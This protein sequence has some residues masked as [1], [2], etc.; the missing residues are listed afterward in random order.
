MPAL[1][2]PVDHEGNTAATA[3][4]LGSL[5]LRNTASGSIDMAGDQDFFR[6]TAQH[7]GKVTINIS[8]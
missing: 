5:D 2:G 8:R 7:T 3:V 4:N 1:S 6:F